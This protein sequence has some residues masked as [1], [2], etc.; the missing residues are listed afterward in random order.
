MFI[1]ESHAFSPIFSGENFP[2]NNNN[3]HIPHEVLTVKKKMKKLF[4]YRW[5][6]VCAEYFASKNIK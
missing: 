6:N 4:N 5:P 3:H 2:K 1:V